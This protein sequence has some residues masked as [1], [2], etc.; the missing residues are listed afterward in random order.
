MNSKQKSKIF[1]IILILSLIIVNYSFFDKSLENFLENSETGV[2]QR[3][4]D[5]DTVEINNESVRL[6]GI[7]CPEKGEIFSLEAKQFL[8]EKILNQTVK[9]KFGKDKYD[10]YNRKLAYIYFE[11]KNINL[12]IVEKGFANFYFPSGKDAY[13]AK[14]LSAWEKCLEREENLCEKSNSKCFNCISLEELNIENQ[15]VVLKNN[16]AFECDLSNWSIKDQGRKKFVFSETKLGIGES[17]RI[18]ATD[19]N[20]D[21]VWTE[22]GDSLFLR[23]ATKKLVLWDNY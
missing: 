19:F 15:I 22:S 21:Y 1:L 5:G 6:L 2:V 20:K 17:I 11:N 8:E 14:F 9:L 12:E 3:V 7:N 18:T 4:I 16:C 10:I 23:D 13:Y